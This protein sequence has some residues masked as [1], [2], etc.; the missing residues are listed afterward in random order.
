MSIL[1][2]QRRYSELYRIRLGDRSGKQPRSL[3]GEI[4]ITSPNKTVIKAFADVYGG[5]PRRWSDQGQFQVYL[6]TVR[7]PI[8]LLPGQNLSQHM[9]LWQGQT[10]QRR[11]NGYTMQDGS[12]CACGADKPLEDRACKPVTRLTV[13]CP[14]VPAVGVGLLTTRSAIAAGE[15]EGQLALA[16]AVLAQGK[17]VSAILRIDRLVTPGHT[18]VVPRLELQDLTWGEAIGAGPAAPALAA[19]EAP[20]LE[21]G[22]EE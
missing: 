17:A 4:R 10:C 12:D 21:A 7:L 1:N 3:D 22:E 11:C 20:A 9:E 16:N 6:P 5:R 2:I 15:M 14:E 8:A 18:F 19:P 13:A